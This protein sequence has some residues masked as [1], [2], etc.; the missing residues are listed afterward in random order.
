MA[1]AWWKEAVIY[2]V[3]P[4]IELMRPPPLSVLDTD[5]PHRS[6]LRHSWI[7]M[8]TVGEMSKVSRRNLITSKSWAWI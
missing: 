6:T 4:S 2:Q 5:F 7:A 1:E 8:E 3:S